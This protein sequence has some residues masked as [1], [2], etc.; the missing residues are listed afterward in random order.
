MAENFPLSA[1]RFSVEWGAGDAAFSEVSG[2]TMEAEVLEYRSGDS[3]ENH[4]QKVP[5]LVKY[6]NVTLKRGIIDAAGIVAFYEWIAEPLG[7]REPRNVTITLN[8]EAGTG[9]L[10]W[11]LVGAFPVKVEGPALKS[12][13][14]D[15]AIES[16]ELAVTSASVKAG[17][18]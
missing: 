1:L 11:N 14:T 16:M 8:D 17:A 7:R 9:V 5:A 13:G 12:T 15:L 10:T 6:G 3:R 2:L 4:T 18:A